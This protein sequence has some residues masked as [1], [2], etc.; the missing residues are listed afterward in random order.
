MNTIRILVIDDDISILKLIEKYLK[1][2][3][4]NFNFNIITS[5]NARK[6]LNLVKQ[7]KP[8]IILLDIKMPEMDGYEFSSQ[9]QNSEEFSSIPVIF[10]SALNR[11]EDKVRAFVSGAVDY[12]TKPINN[13]KLIE[14]I[15][16]HI[17]KATQLINIPKPTKQLDM[18]PDISEFKEF[19]Y[20]IFN[21]TSDKKN[22][23]NK[24]DF[25][26]LYSI[27]Y[28]LEIPEN[29]LSK[30]VSEF[31]NMP[32][33]PIIN[34]E[35]IKLGVLPLPFCKKQTVIPIDNDSGEIAFVISNP[36]CFDLIDTLEK[37]LHKPQKNK[38]MITWPENIETIL[39]YDMEDKKVSL[40]LDQ[41]LKNIT[42]TKRHQSQY[43]IKP[44]DR[45][46]KY[47]A[48]N[49]LKYAVSERA[50]DIHIEPKDRIAIVRFRIDGDLRSIY[51]LNKK[52]SVKLIS[53][54][55]ALGG[56][57]ITDKRRPQG[58]IVGSIIEGNSFRLR[59][60]TTLTINGESLTIRL[61]HSS[62]A[63]DLSVLGMTDKQTQLM[64]DFAKRKEGLLLFVGPTGSGKTS[65][66][67]SVLSK[68][69]SQ[70]QSLI[71]VEDPVE[72]EIPFANQQQVNEKAGITFDALLKSS[73]RQDPDILF[74]GEI[75]D[76]GSA[77]IAL[78]FASTGHLTITSLHTANAATAIFRLER[79]GI[80]RSTMAD[81]I[82]GIVAQRLL[83]KL[84]NKCKIISS[85]TKDEI[86]MIL[87]YTRNVPSEVARP[88]GCAKC[89][90]T[91]HYGR[92]G[93]FEIIKYDGEILKMIRSGHPISKVRDFMRTRGDYLISDSAIEKT[94]N[95]V[96]SPAEVFKKVLPDDTELK[97]EEIAAT[98]VDHAGD[99][100]TKSDS[101]ISILIV[102][103]DK[104]TQ[105]LL[106]QFL[107]KAGY[108]AEVS[109]SGVEALNFL[110]ERKYNLIVSDVKMPGLDGFQLIEI[111]VIKEITTPVI[112]LTALD[113]DADVIKGLK[114]GAA[115]YITKPIQ[116]EIFLFRVKKALKE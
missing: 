116:K 11:E 21:L 51:N 81:S 72:Y 44:E 90:Y 111:L 66:I 76:K 114:L 20:G 88:V 58:G 101:M 14:T 42:I 104:D 4:P 26:H 98:E 74:I 89:D 106:S 65:T 22:K 19:L 85:I 91:G 108:H 95:F 47:I 62:K 29:R 23:I 59:L 75:R 43:I 17:E 27:A 61:I 96:F 87:P 70:N 113:S 36:F 5:N 102:E 55:K 10:V 16:K 63:K 12:L 93:I 31:T 99:E 115:D 112:F 49:I 45:N 9:L 18:Y 107:N 105:K 54:L 46:I 57:D 79:L 38:Y 7:M 97:T 69:D 8:D 110:K 67:H 40:F 15:A 6:A 37:L 25:S 2:N 50:S 68:V 53:R 84:C 33:V 30:L 3:G 35:T 86:K 78:D 64:L 100:K 71:S 103:D 24:I 80:S 34:P 73:V 32:F 1:K 109:S 92:E 48:N 94:K 41:K 83:K 60:A 52:T 39:K 77:Q 82:I 13:K 28:Y 56:L